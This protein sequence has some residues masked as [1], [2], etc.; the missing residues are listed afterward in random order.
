MRAA[1]WLLALFATAVAVALFVGDN[2]AT[3]TLFWSPWRVDLSLNLVLVVLVAA[4]A[5]LHLTSRALAALFELPQRAQ[6]WR[7]Q[8]RERAAHA[9]LVESLAALVAG[10]FTRSRKA[11]AAVLGRLDSL[12]SGS[13]ALA[14]AGALRALARLVAAQSA[15]A[16]QDRSAREEQLQAVLG[17]VS[18]GT[19]AGPVVL[20]LR[21]GAR[22]QAAR[23]SLDER[24]AEAAL[25]WLDSLPQGAQRRTLALRIRL[26]ASRLAQ[27]VPEALETARL[28]AKHRAFTPQ[29]AQT[30][31]RS[32]VADLLKTA[33]DPGQLQRLWGGLPAA[34]QRMPDVAM[35]AARQLL[36]LGD[37]A[38]RSR[39]W[40]E[41]VWQDWVRDPSTLAPAQAER[42]T[43]LLE[44][45]LA[46]GDDEADR[47]W[48]ARIE[49]AH[50]AH[51]R[52]VR[53]QHL[54][55]MACMRRQLWGKAE[56]LLRQS[57]ATPDHEA[58]ARSAW[59]A[60]AELAE[61]RGDADAA[62][63][64]WKRAAQAGT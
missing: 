11:A 21:E 55:G 61:R 51:A 9:A 29:A 25:T 58:L 59:R 27:R 52:D 15:H 46:T 17:D 12:E 31:V 60:L 3:V 1:L 54:A 41:P 19:S 38:A 43:L 47:A 23:W 44:R 32:L 7:A 57:V 45:C 35:A 2:R 30:L 10:R 16:L 14:H 37:D 40:L 53:L 13:G 26:K 20:E 62:L 6:A 28:L 36:A 8:Q 5:V 64:A 39:A 49:S 4:F 50:Q 22:L 63:Q 34:E 48:L 18:A 42:L 33:H 56:L 24:D